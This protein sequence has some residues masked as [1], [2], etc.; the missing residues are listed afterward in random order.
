MSLV[1]TRCIGIS[2]CSNANAHRV[3]DDTRGDAK[4]AGTSRGRLSPCTGGATLLVADTKQS[5]E[6]S[7]AM[8]KQLNGRARTVVIA[9][10][11]L[12]A[13]VGCSSSEVG[14]GPTGKVGDSAAAPAAD[15]SDLSTGSALPTI[16]ADALLLQ[17][18]KKGLAS[19]LD[20]I[21]AGEEA[22]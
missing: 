21:P 4:P 17:V 14:S 9:L 6:E 20:A 19:F 3:G 1:V 22:E 12:A 8:K 18:A 15:V 7:S 16:G 10:A 2:T 13:V 5:A 11:G